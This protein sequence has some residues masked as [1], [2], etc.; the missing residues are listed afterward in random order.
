MGWKPFVVAALILELERV[1]LLRVRFAPATGPTHPNCAA[2]GHVREAVIH[3]ANS[4]TMPR[5][6]LA[7]ELLDGPTQGDDFVSRREILDA[8]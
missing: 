1:V 8:R 5:V 4:G 2:F 6:L 7:V 3:K